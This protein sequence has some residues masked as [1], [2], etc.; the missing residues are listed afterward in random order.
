[1]SLSQFLSPY[2][3]PC[4]G[5]GLSQFLY[6]TVPRLEMLPMIDYCL[7]EQE[8]RDPSDGSHLGGLGEL[9][10]PSFSYCST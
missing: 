4:C 7:H 9:T 6:K 8:P 5:T 1:M 10:M 3:N 2:V